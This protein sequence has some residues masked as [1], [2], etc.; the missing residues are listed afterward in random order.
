M[1]NYMRFIIWQPISAMPP[2][3]VVTPFIGLEFT[4]S[5]QMV[6]ERFQSGV[7]CAFCF[8]QNAFAL[9]SSVLRGGKPV[10]KVNRNPVFAIAR[11]VH[12]VLFAQLLLRFNGLSLWEAHPARLMNINGNATRKTEWYGCAK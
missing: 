10:L 12:E 4:I 9:A 11:T 8:L 3:R 5:E 6:A 7:L 2:C 1:N